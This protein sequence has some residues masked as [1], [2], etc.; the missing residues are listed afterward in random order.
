MKMTLFIGQ[1]S[2]LV[3]EISYVLTTCKSENMSTMVRVRIGH[4]GEEG[5]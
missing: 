4:S 5:E 3:R 2:Q 1:K